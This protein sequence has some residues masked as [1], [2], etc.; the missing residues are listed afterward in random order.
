MITS[1]MARGGHPSRVFVPAG[2]QGGNGLR[3]L[4]DSLIVTHSLAT[5]HDSEIDRV[6][7]HLDRLAELDTALRTTLAL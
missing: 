7:G 2:S 5:L 6:I 4:M 1:I 3:L